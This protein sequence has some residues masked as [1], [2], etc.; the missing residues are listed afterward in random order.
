MSSR[1]S[2][3]KSR[4]LAPAQSLFTGRTTASQAVR[5]LHRPYDRGRDTA[6][7]GTTA[8]TGVS[9]RVAAG[10]GAEQAARTQTSATATGQAGP[11]YDDTPCR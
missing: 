6:S 2:P 10:S 1:P 11:A 7:S 5:P 8:G 9:R 3:S 4:A